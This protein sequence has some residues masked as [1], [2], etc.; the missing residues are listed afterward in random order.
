MSQEF[1]EAATSGDVSKV[2]AMLQ[3]DPT[4]AR[5]RDENGVSVIMKSTY[6]GKRDVVTALLEGPTRL[7]TCVAATPAIPSMGETRRVK[8]R[9]TVAVSRAAVAALPAAFCPMG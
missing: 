1:L 4:L 6:Y 8:P 3:V 2:K 5:A 9:F 7:P